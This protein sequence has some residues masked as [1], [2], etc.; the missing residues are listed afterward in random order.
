MK[1][2]QWTRWVMQTARTWADISP[3]MRETGIETVDKDHR[4]MIEHALELNQ[5]I[6]RMDKEFNLEALK[7]QADLL[8]TLHEYTVG[9]FG[10]EEVILERYKSPA[11][12]G[13]R[14][15]HKRILDMLSAA[16]AD[17]E[18]GK[19][20][21]TQN[22]KLAIFEWVINHVNEMDY[23]AF[24]VQGLHEALSRAREWQDI[25]E[26][27]RMT[28]IKIIDDDHRQLGESILRLHR[29][30]DLARDKDSEDDSSRQI[31]ER[32]HELHSCAHRHFDREIEF[33][34]N[35]RVQGLDTQMNQHEAFLTTISGHI[36]NVTASGA[37]HA[38]SLKSTIMHW[39]VHHVNELDYAIFCK[40]DWAQRALEAAGSLAQVGGLIQKTGITEVDHD[41]VALAETALE[42]N[43][44]LG[45]TTVDEQS[46]RQKGREIFDKM[47][48]L[49]EQHFAREE[50]IMQEQ[51]LEAY[52]THR[53]EHQRL[54]TA[55]E[56]FRKQ[57]IEGR[58]GISQ[59][60]KTTLLQW[61]INHTNG[62]D[63]ATF[64]SED[65]DNGDG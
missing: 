25:A 16:S 54:L 7:A 60:L 64:G 14:R 58:V 43:H 9:H 36:E 32:L 50:G 38:E 18:A 5:L 53:E 24:S 56:N 44:L 34:Q 29:A 47:Y 48:A 20:T 52:D 35:Y 65:S 27:V 2:E 40:S 57:L 1:E 19:T 59:S 41:H 3:I 62:T 30:L 31:L 42:I 46:S 33:M 23:N 51:A 11:L 13:Q 26:I 55:V 39:L 61:L 49:A 12:D 15:Q 17:F 45:D 21:V 28:G 37:Q 4:R 22:L 63:I 10:R 8:K 6:A